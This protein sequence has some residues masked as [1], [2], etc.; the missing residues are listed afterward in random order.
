MKPK[1]HT[2]Y[3]FE[4]PNL[5]IVKVWKAD[6]LMNKN[7]RIIEKNILEFKERLDL[8]GEKRKKIIIMINSQWELVQ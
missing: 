5:L 1:Y 6:H 7:I 4:I 3:G 8:L 2:L